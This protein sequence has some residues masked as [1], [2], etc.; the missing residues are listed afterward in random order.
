LKRRP[1]PGMFAGAVT[2]GAMSLFATPASASL[3]SVL[4]SITPTGTEFTW[5]YQVDLTSGV[6]EPGDFLMIYD[7]EGYVRG[8]ATGGSSWSVSSAFLGSTPGGISPT[9]SPIEPNLTFTYIGP[10]VNSFSG[11]FS[12]IS[13]LGT[14]GEAQFA[15]QYTRSSGD[16]ADGTKIFNLGGIS[17]PSSSGTLADPLPG[18]ATPQ[19]TSILPS[20]AGS[21]GYDYCV[22]TGGTLQSGDSF[23][24]YD[25]QGLISASAQPSWTASVQAL[26]VTATG[27]LPADDPVMPNVTFTYSGA[28]LTGLQSCV[29]VGQ[30]ESS[31]SGQGLSPFTARG[32]A[33]A[34]LSALGSVA[35][36]GSTPQPVP[37]PAIALL[38]VTGA[39]AACRR[40]LRGK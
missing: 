11:T 17:V 29:T 15:S 28:P 1:L 7:F 24:L 16:L 6:L 27:T 14:A 2:L 26:G 20:G 31:L 36:P 3:I 10:E 38:L 8:S 25:V 23:T 37:E 4:Q 19:L 40:F 34:G 22:E 35:V 30:I 12:I 33:G 9:D 18:V 39:A 13:T 5:T 21:F 32:A